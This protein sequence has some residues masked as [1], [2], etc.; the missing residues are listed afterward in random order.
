MIIRTSLLFAKRDELKQFE[1][2]IR[3]R[4]VALDEREKE[5]AGRE[6]SLQAREDLCENRE[7]EAKETQRKLNQAAES[8]RGQ[9]GRFREEKEQWE[10]YREQEEKTKETAFGVTDLP[11]EKCGL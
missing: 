1:D 8:L 9:W 3:A 4:A 2:Q 10:K 6:A 5:L 11:D 7:A